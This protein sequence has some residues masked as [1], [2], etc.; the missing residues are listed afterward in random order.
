MSRKQSGTPRPDTGQKRKFSFEVL[1][2]QEFRAFAEAS[3]QS[4]FQQTVEMANLRR[5]HGMDVDFV[6]MRE[7]GEIKAGAVFATHHA[8][9]ATF[10]SVISGPLCDYDDDELVAEFLRALARFAKKKGAVH[11]DIAPNQRYRVR[12]DHGEALPERAGGA[13]DTRMIRNIDQAG[14]EH[15]GFVRGYTSTVRWRFAKDMTGIGDESELLKSYSKRTQWSIKRARSMG[16]HV[17]EIGVDELDTFA[18]IEQQTA[19][20]RHFEFRGPQYFKQSAQCFGERARFVLAEIDTAEYQRSMQRKADDLRALVDGL[21]AKIA[22]RETTKLRR[23]L[24]EESSNL[25]AANK[26]LAEANELVEKGD[27]IPAAA[28]MFVLGPREVVYLVSGSV[29]EYQPF[30]ASALIQHEAMLRY[31]VQGVEPF[32]HV[33]LYD[34]YGIDGIFDDPD[35]EGR[36]VLVFKQGFNGYVGEMPGDFMK[37]LR[38]VTYRAQRLAHKLLGR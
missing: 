13:P 8:P 37:V 33:N 38:P 22:Q 29:E 15:G 17:R 31:C 2:E 28:S 16:V 14:Y 5:M 24:N 34:F 20:R 9:M 30:Y 27:L 35:D 36:G 4:N 26:R 1:N 7:D 10:C 21:E 18:R 12:D 25:A 6:G 11:L 23:R 19:E 32:G 3:P